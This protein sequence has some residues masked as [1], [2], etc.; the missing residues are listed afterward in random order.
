VPLN[1][2]RL[3]PICDRIENNGN[4]NRL[5]GICTFFPWGRWGLYKN[6]LSQMWI[7]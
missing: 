5:A 6:P 4:L 2:A 3:V 7:T 1:L